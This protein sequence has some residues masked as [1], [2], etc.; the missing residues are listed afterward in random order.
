MNNKGRKIKDLKAYENQ[1]N[2]YILTIYYI[3]KSFVWTILICL[4]LNILFCDKAY[5]C[6][7]LYIYYIIMVCMT[8]WKVKKMKT[9]GKLIRKIK[10]INTLSC[11]GSNIITVL[12]FHTFDFFW[13]YYFDTNFY[14]FPYIL[15]QLLL[16]PF[17]TNLK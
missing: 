17:R 2:Y 14:S 12:L 5:V 16:D 8:P 9:K 15:F 1:K 4:K 7:M 11:Y 10:A 6:V 13:I 3:I